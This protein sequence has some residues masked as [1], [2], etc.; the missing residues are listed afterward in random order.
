MPQVLEKV[1]RRLGGKLFLKGD[2]CLGPK[3]AAIRRAYPPGAHGKSRRRRRDSEYANLLHEKQRVRYVYGLD[4]RELERYNKIATALKGAVG[5]NLLKILERRLDNAV[6]R[7]GFALSRRSARQTVNHGHILVNEKIMTIPS[8]QIKKGER[9]SIKDR[10]RSLRLF[11][12]I[13]TRLKNYDPPRW[14]S[15]DKSKPEGT[16]ID[17]P[18]GE[19]SEAIFDTAKI[20]EFYSR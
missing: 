16:V 10:A 19:E 9:I 20:R 5:S 17:M 11:S 2:R 3:C 13:D 1:E 6:Y 7:L 12:D 8:Y 18:S 14:L 4:D 15:L